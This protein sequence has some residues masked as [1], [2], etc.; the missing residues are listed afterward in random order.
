VEFLFFPEFVGD[1]NTTFRFFAIVLFAVGACSVYAGGNM[2]HSASE[3]ELTFIK[4]NKR[5]PDLAYQ[6]FLRNQSNWQNFL[7]SNGNWWVQFN[8][9]NQKPHRAYGKPIAVQGASPEQKALNFVQQHLSD[10]EIPFNDLVWKKSIPTSKHTYVHFSQKHQGLQVLGSKLLVKLDAQGRVILFGTDVYSDISLNVQAFLSPANAA[11]Q[12]MY[13]LNETILNTEVK[14]ELCIL[15]IPEN[16]GNNYRLVYQVEIETKDNDGIPARYYTLV[17]AHNGEVLYRHNTIRHMHGNPPPTGIEIQMQGE[18][19]PNN[20]F[21]PT[22]VVPFPDL[23]FVVSGNAFQTDA[24]GT[25]VTGISG[26]QNVNFSLSGNWVNV[27]TNA[28]TPVF[29]SLCNDGPNTITFSPSASNIR[30]RSAFYHVNVAHDHCKSVLPTFTGM[31]FS[32]P[33]NIDVS[34]GTCNAYYDGSSINFFAQGGG[35]T[36]FATVADVIY[37]EYGHGINHSFYTDGGSFFNNGAMD[38]GYAD[39]W[40]Y[41]ITQQ[42]IIGLGTNL[43]NVNSFIRRYDINRKVYPVNIVGEVH[44]DGEIIAGAWWDTYLLLGNDMNL[45]TQLFADA[46]PGYQAEVFNGNEGQAFTDVLIDVLQAD[47]T[48]GDLT[49][50]T[51]NGMAIATAFDLHGI[52]LISNA[53]LSHQAVLASPEAVNISIDVDLNLTFPYTDYVDQIFC[54]YRVNQG[55]W[56]S[57]SMNLVSGNSYTASIPGQNL[58]DVVAYYIGAS[59]LNGNISAVLPFGANA[60]NPTLPYFVMVGYALHKT[61]DSDG[62]QQFGNWTLGDVSDNATNGQW[63]EGVILGSFMTFGIPESVVQPD[64]QNTFGGTSCFYTKNAPNADDAAGTADVDGGA[65]TLFSPV[66]DLS[67]Y[68]NPAISYYRWYTNSKGVNPNADWW[69]VMISGD[70]TNWVYVEN[71][72]TSEHAWRRNVIRVQD[73]ITPSNT[74]QLK[75]IASDS[76]RP[77]VSQNGGSLVEA[78]LDDFMLWDEINVNGLENIENPIFT[79]FPNPSEGIF[80][81]SWNNPDFIS[82]TISVFDVTGR[83]MISMPVNGAKSISLDLTQFSSGI[84]FVRFENEFY[85][86]GGHLLLEK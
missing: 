66:L 80:T 23:S 60:V 75:F 8:E 19:Y 21:D 74:V 63:E 28:A 45:T 13:N 72:P 35:C 84:Y 55:A 27:Q 37:H 62:L 70:G 68:V 77:T 71:T 83:A 76:I 51:P 3:Y 7:H 26:P 49:N 25:S 18:I 40:A 46:F 48:D 15:P 61:H 17:D 82:G 86:V 41:S 9:E 6:Q 11:S 52:T 65:T 79:I 64:T 24:F 5:L 57:L 54:N 50:G 73:Y 29:S 56:Q 81:I 43:S 39:F 14:Q 53:S 36:S 20:S 1:M 58:G 12:A 4:N 69:Q 33:A 38:E 42:A 30:E 47:D 78:A 10:F 67:G 22:V 32:L 31:D 16:K 2:Y 59:D 34:P 44:A 85:Q